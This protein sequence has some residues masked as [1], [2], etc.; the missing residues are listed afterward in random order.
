MTGA[1]GPAGVAVIRELRRRGHHVI[2]VDADPSAVGF[3]LASEGHV[4]PTWDDPAF[5]DELV[6]VAS[7]A[8]ARAL[9]STVAEEFRAIDADGAGGSGRPHACCPD[10]EA[11]HRCLD[12]WAFVE[13]MDEA[14][15]ATP[16]TGLGTPDGVPGPWIVKPRFGRGSRDVYVPR[17]VDP[18]EG[19][20]ATGRPTPSC[21]RW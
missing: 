17:N 21:R 16:A 12:K 2:A 15:V 4:V 18:A 5:A 19:G 20:A 6:A 9:I 1:G 7:E 10:A 3:E 14:G 8:D 13:A 11:V